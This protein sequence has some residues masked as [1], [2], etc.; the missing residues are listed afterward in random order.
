MQPAFAKQHTAPAASAALFATA[1]N[2]EHW[3]RHQPIKAYMPAQDHTS[4][5]APITPAVV[6]RTATEH[7]APAVPADALSSRQQT[8]TAAQRNFPE[9]TAAQ[10]I[11][12]IPQVPGAYAANSEVAF[13]STERSSNS[14]AVHGLLKTA[15]ELPSG[16]L[17]VSSSPDAVQETS[18]SMTAQPE[19]YD[20]LCAAVNAVVQHAGLQS[21]SQSKAS[22]C[23]PG[24]ADACYAATA[25]SGATGS[26]AAVHQQQQHQQQQQHTGKSVLKSNHAGLGTVSAQLQPAAGRESPGSQADGTQGSTASGK[27]LNAVSSPGP[28]QAWQ[29]HIQQAVAVL[30]SALQD[31]QQP[32][33]TTHHRIAAAH[34]E[35]AS[36][37]KAGAKAGIS[38][39]VGKVHREEQKPYQAQS[40]SNESQ[41]AQ[42]G[43]QHN[44]AMQCSTDGM[45]STQQGSRLQ[46]SSS[47]PQPAQ[48]RNDPVVEIEDLQPEASWPQI[49][50]QGMHG[51]QQ[52]QF[53]AGLRS[54]SRQQRQYQAGPGSQHHQEEQL[55][56]HLTQQQQER[57]QG[58]A[59]SM[60]QHHRQ[61]ALLQDNMQGTTPQHQVQGVRR[62]HHV[63]G[64]MPQH[65]MQGRTPQHQMQGIDHNQGQ[66]RHVTAQR[67]LY[68]HGPMIPTKPS[69]GVQ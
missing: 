8:E 61:D 39:S 23:L 66:R 49:W 4:E 48:E 56:A 17:E 68:K 20:A 22:K 40:Q 69:T 37:P 47:E 63:Q 33:D 50:P 7:P 3:N 34:A 65:H 27:G 25:V 26:P 32:T 59:G 16:K 55:E 64:T 30:Q 5:P 52:G 54:K 44:L 57:G 38:N 11:H 28:L 24:P 12:H 10:L 51:Q 36:E 18:I 21:S 62:Q 2:T 45:H 14:A 6:P 53:Q 15:R 46:H 41:H 19:L 29:S 1:A 35:A 31:S 43:A 9:S 60:P 67:R 13:D 42:H 58:Q